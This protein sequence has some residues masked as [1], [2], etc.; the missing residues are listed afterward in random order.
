MTENTGFNSALI[1]MVFAK[2]MVLTTEE[3]QQFVLD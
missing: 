2:N 3:L 1:R